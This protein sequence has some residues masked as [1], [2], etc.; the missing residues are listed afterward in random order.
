M[1]AKFAKK[2]KK[3]PYSSATSPKSTKTLIVLMG[4]KAWDKGKSETWFKGSKVVLP[5]GEPVKQYDWSVAQGFGDAIVWQFGGGETEER[6]REV[7]AR[8]LAYVPKVVVMLNDSSIA[9]CRAS[10]AAA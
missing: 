9:F 1:N 7:V 10:E 6:I 3:L 4:D 8:L 5:Q 2:R